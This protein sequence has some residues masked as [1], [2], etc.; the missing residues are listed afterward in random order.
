[1]YAQ[2][3]RELG[4]E[5]PLRALIPGTASQNARVSLVTGDPKEAGGK[6]SGRRTE[7]GYKA[8]QAGRE[9]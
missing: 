7:T 5:S 8:T 2:H 9:G 3:D 1:M 6:P 4:G